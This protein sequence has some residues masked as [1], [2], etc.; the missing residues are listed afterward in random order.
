MNAVD[1]IKEICAERKIA[2]SRLEKDLG[3]SNGYIAQIKDGAI[4][5][6]RLLAIA[7]YLGVEPAYL[8]T[9][10]KEKPATDGDGFESEFNLSDNQKK[11]LKLIPRLSEQETTRL[12]EQ[13]K[14][15]ILGL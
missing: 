10:E 3:F 14:E 9:G 13:V 11:L 15:T 1:R 4:R 5:A 12:L 7:S 8:L 6:D 2:I